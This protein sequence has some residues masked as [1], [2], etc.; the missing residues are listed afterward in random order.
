MVLDVLSDEFE[1]SSNG[2][3][4]GDGQCEGDCEWSFACDESRGEGG[5]GEVESDPRGVWEEW[6]EGRWEGSDQSR[7]GLSD[8]RSWVGGGEEL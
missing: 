6:R 3:G 1:G 4:R 5:D 8:G 2:E 7:R